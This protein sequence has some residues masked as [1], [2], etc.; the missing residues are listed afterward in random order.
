MEYSLHA[1]L[2]I[3]SKSQKEEIELGYNRLINEN[4][5]GN[6]K[7]LIVSN[8]FHKSTKTVYSDINILKGELGKVNIQN[9]YAFG[10]EA[11]DSGIC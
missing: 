4:E 1:I 7:F 6:F 11:P 3:C 10:G 9:F 8:D 2:E 5:M